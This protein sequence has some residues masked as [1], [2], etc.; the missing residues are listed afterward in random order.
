MLPSFT[1]LD[2]SDVSPCNTEILG[3]FDIG[4]FVGNYFNYILLGKFCMT[5][6]FSEALLVTAFCISVCNIVGMGAKE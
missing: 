5:L 3:Y 6:F 2:P 4:S 1:A